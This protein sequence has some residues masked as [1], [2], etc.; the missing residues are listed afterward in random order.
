H[1]LGGRNQ[2]LALSAAIA[3]R[4]WDRVVVLSVGSDGRD[5]PT[6]AAGA[7][8]DGYTYG[9]AL[10]LGLKPEEFLNRN[11]SYSFFKKVGGHVFTGYTGTNV[12]DFVVVV[13]EKEK[14]WD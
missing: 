1:G 5:G 3:L 13:V 12:N 9:R 4:G 7:V 2:E 14:V 10:E 8:V 11:D 6:D